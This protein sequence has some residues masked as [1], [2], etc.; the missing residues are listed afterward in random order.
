MDCSNYLCP[1]CVMAHQF[2]H[3]FEGHRVMNLS[4]LQLQ[5][6]GKEEIKSA[7]D[8]VVFCPRHKTD[9]LKYF[10]RSCNVPI[11]KE[12]TMLDHPNGIHDYEHISDVGP[13]QVS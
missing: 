8:K 3:C 6:G 5:N 12:C 4:E 9:A 7:V 13:K 2:M 1:N 10:C 11:C